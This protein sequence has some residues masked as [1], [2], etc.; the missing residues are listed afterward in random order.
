MTVACQ[1]DFYVLQD[2]SLSAEQL[3]CRLALMAWEQGNR[4]MVLAQNKAQ[5]QR[6][7]ELMWDYPQGRFLPH[8]QKRQPVPAPVMVG[9]MAELE[10]DAGEVIINLTQDAVPQPERFRRLLELV[11]ANDAQR[12]ASRVK[13][14]EYRSRGLEP[15]SHPINTLK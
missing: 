13:F 15:A 5:A 10:D 12:Q 14:R 7:D 6:L 2:E 11:P 8:A 1:V 3:T 4:I 9:V